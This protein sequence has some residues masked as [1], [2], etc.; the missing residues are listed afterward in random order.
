MHR[1]YE[2]EDITVF[3]DSDKCRHARECVSGSPEVFEFGRR[4][5][6][7][8][9]RGSS[10]GI[11]QTVQRC[12]SGALGITYNHGVRI[13]YDEK[14]HRSVA[15]LDGKEIGEC[16]YEIA[17]VPAAG[18]GRSSEYGDPERSEH[19]D[20]SADPVSETVWNIYHTHVL[21]EHG[22]KNIAKRLVYCLA[23]TAERQGIRIIPGCSYAA[24]V[25]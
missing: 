22:G 19:P 18:L 17:D 16:D 23:E 2:T 9:T 10:A 15:V 25:L 20:S 7:D 5:W 14:N 12:P 8:L 3:W 6:I 24:K 21:P 11:W 1:M 13:S 4:P